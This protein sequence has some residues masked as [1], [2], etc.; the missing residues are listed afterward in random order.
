MRQLVLTAPRALEWEELPEPAA[1][2]PGEALV[3]PIAV[4]TCDLDP[5]IVHGGW[6]LPYPIPLG[7]EFVAEVV[8]AGEG[9]YAPVGD[10]VAVPFQ[11]SC[12]ECRYCARGLTGNCETTP[13]RAT[14]GFGADGGDYGG[15]FADLV[16]VP[17]AD[18]MVVPLPAGVDPA[19]AAS[20][21]DNMADGY[22]AVAAGLEAWPGGEVL[23][24]GGAG[25]S[26]GLYA[27]G[28]AVALGAARTVYLDS[29]PS[30]L[31]V[32]EALGAEAVQ[33]DGEPPRKT[34]P[35]E[36]TVDA[37]GDPAGLACALRSTA[38]DGVSNSVAGM[39]YR[40]VPMPVSRM[41]TYCCTFKTGRVHARPAMPALLELIAQ[42]SLH[43]ELVTSR[44]CSFEE[45]AEALL[46]PERKLV[47]VRE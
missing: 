11:I 19:Q 46:E 24:V 9:T 8:A 33:H 5:L 35:F 1:P 7:H 28:S 44:T 31:E 42:G 38:P 14:Y 2:A 32:A 12:G 22:S 4:A 37:S 6:P 13:H 15:A 20:V 3:R 27:A 34:G 25:Q 43:P 17:F 16:R 18:R 30:R 26:I 41:Y 21:G 39:I 45:A 40:D 29:D 47:A 23:V 10:V 36:V